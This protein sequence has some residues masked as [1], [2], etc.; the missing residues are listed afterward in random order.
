MCVGLALQQNS[1]SYWRLSSVQDTYEKEA[2]SKQCNFKNMH[3]WLE[4]HKKPRVNRS[5]RTQT[6]FTKHDHRC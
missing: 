1:N 2:I 5:F 3:A 6:K 4:H